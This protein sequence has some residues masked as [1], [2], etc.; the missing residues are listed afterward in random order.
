M[1]RSQMIRSADARAGEAARDRLA[2]VPARAD[3]DVLAKVAI[4]AKQLRRNEDALV[5]DLAAMMAREIDQ[6]DSDPKL[7]EMLEASVHGNVSTII[8]VLALSL[9]HI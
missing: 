1:T 7:V 8:H 5:A 9:I 6:L 4:I 3:A 2:S